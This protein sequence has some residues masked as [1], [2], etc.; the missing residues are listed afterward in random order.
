MVSA[1]AGQPPDRAVGSFSGGVRLCRLPF[2]ARDDGGA[3]RF[4]PEHESYRDGDRRDRPGGSLPGTDGDRRD[5]RRECTVQLARL[6]TTAVRPARRQSDRKAGHEGAVPWRDPAGRVPS[7]RHLA[8]PVGQ[9]QG[10]DFCAEW[11]ELAEHD[12]RDHRLKVYG[13]VDQPVE[14]SRDD[15]QSMG[16]QTQITL[17]HCIQGWS[18]IAAWSGWPMAELIRRAQ[19]KPAAR[20]VVFFSFGEGAE[21][22][23]FYDSLSLEDAMHP[24]TL[25]AW[26]MNDSPLTHLHGAPLRL[27]VE[28][29]LGFK[30]VKWIQAIE[31]VASVR[32]IYLGEGGYNED[33]EY[34]G[35]LANI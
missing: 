25:L 20:A 8:V 24:Q 35:E 3:D 6:A 23:Q 10:T 22:G 15:L 1:A 2:S 19:P 32:S 31:F 14:L 30:M 28:N 7:R 4:R 9:R 12:F 13:L 17:H 21:G 27:R 33:H 5:R 16:K 18:G 11:L 29:Q 26:E 34:F